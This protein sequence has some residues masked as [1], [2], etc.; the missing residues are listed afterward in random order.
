MV[1]LLQMVKF[2]LKARSQLKSFRQKVDPPKLAKRLFGSNLSNF[3]LQL[4][5]Y[6]YSKSNF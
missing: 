6:S 3:L 1:H 4:S 5:F 2:Q